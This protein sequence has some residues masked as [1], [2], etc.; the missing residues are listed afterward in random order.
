MLARKRRRKNLIAV[1]RDGRTYREPAGRFRPSHQARA[2]L[3]V[4][5]CSRSR[6]DRM[7]LVGWKATIPHDPEQAVAFGR[8]LADLI[9]RW[10]PVL[11]A[12][13]IV[14]TPP[15][16]ASA[17]RG[18]PDAAALIGAAAAD[19]LG[20]RYAPMLTRT[21]RKGRHG[22]WSSREQ[23]PYEVLLIPDP[24]SSLVLCVDDAATS[25]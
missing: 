19:A 18:L 5:A 4:W 12:D 11:P 25:G 23:A 10:S 24:R 3:G 2:C 20:L 15:S 8:A 6:A 1:E 7:A 21:D 22:P 17:S 14:T 16:G 13:A 9:R